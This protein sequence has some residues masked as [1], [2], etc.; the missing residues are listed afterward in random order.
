[1]VMEDKF[2][3]SGGTLDEEVDDVLAHF[4]IPGMKWGR[5]KGSS[6]D[7]R[8]R[9]QAKLNKPTREQRRQAKLASQS[10]EYKT[11]RELKAKSYKTLSNKELKAL[12]ERMQLEKS[13]RDLKSS[14]LQ[15][16]L[17][18]VKTLTAIGTTVASLYALSTTP[19]GQAV[20]KAITRN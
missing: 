5:K 8:A 7:P 3:N 16:G 12:N 1:M 17:D 6:V 9:R 13:L 18:T 4:G 19:L 20:K 14:D 10:D 11:S 15:K 2:I